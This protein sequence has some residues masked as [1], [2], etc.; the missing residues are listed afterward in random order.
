[1][2]PRIQSK[3]NTI[4]MNEAMMAPTNFHDLNNWRLANCENDVAHTTVQDCFFLSSF[5]S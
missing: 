4:L 2:N 3:A 1:M 5:R